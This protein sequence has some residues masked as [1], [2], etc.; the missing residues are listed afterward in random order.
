MFKVANLKISFFIKS[1]KGGDA[2]IIILNPGTKDFSRNFREND[3]ISYDMSLKYWG[4]F[5]KNFKSLKKA[6]DYSQLIRAEERMIK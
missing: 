4:S 5:G 6:I 2:L 1:N 3:Y